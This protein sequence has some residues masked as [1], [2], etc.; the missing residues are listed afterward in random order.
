MSAKQGL[1]DARNFERSPLSLN[2]LTSPDMLTDGE[3]I[4]GDGAYQPLTS[5][6]LP[7]V[8]LGDMFRNVCGIVLKDLYYLLSCRSSFHMLM[9][10]A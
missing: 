2:L 6:V 9:M 7:I 1:G 10:A 3:H 5:K 8:D 4:V